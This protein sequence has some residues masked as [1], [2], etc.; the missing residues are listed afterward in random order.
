MLSPLDP[1]CP[2]DND[3]SLQTYTYVEGVLGLGGGGGGGGGERGCRS[4]RRHQTSDKK[5]DCF[6]KWSFLLYINCIKNIYF[7]VMDHLFTLE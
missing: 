7:I 6:A 1:R 2:L 3:M 5:I 4:Q